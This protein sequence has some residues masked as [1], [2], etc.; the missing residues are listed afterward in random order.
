[1]ACGS[2]FREL[3]NHN[4][5]V[6][7]LEEEGYLLDF[8]GGYFLIYGLPYL[9]ERGELAHGD[10]ASPVDLSEPP[11]ICRRPYGLS[12]AAMAGSSSVA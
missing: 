7:N 11:R 9:N 4:R 1:M 8:V 10:W 3:A 2:E 12:Y 5:F 6:Q